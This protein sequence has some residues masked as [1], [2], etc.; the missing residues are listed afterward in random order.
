MKF[1]KQI[2]MFSIVAALVAP[3]AVFAAVPTSGFGKY[4][5][6]GTAYTTV[7]QN[8]GMTKSSIGQMLVNVMNWLM[9][10]LGIGAIISF[11]IAG[12]LYLVAGGDEA[13]T[14][15]AKKMMVYAIIAIVV[16]LVGYVA[17]NTITNL[18]GS[19]AGDNISY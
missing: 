12:I 7:S 19:N 6:G 18:T 4:D 15:N 9:M 10:L 1:L 5:T 3:V 13:K 14:D 16:A 11:V 2:L 8:A 17:V